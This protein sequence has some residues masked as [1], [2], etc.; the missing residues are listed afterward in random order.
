MV[1]DA[2]SRRSTI[3]QC[4]DIDQ[5]GGSP[6]MSSIFRSAPHRRWPALVLGAVAALAGPVVAALIPAPAHAAAT[7]ADLCAQ[8]SYTAGF[9]DDPLVTA[10]AVGLAESSCNPSATHVNGSSG[11]CSSSIDRG[12]YQINS[13]FHAEVSD[14]CAFDAQCNANE[15]FRISSHG[16]NW[17][18]WSAFNSGAYTGHLDEAEAAVERLVP[19][20]P[21]LPRRPLCHPVTGDWDGNGTHTLG[22]VCRDGHGM[23]W[24]LMNI[25]S[26]GTPQ[27]TGGY[28]NSDWCVPVTGDWDGDGRTSA[29]VACKNGTGITWSLSNGFR[30]SP[31]I[32]VFGFGN[33]AN[34][35]PVTGDWDGNG[36]DTIGVACKSGHGLTWSLMNFNGGG[37]PQITGSFGNSDTCLPV[38]GDWDGTGTDTIGVACKSGNGIEWSLINGFAGSPSYPVFGF[39]NSNGCRPVTG[40]WDG[41]GTDT[42]GVACKSGHGL[43]WGLMNFHGGGSP[44]I[45]AGF[46]NGDSYQPTGGWGGP[47]WPAWPDFS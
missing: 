42:I 9:R 41:N 39:G 43:S 30:G 3:H 38:T 29:G 20:P 8:V 2:G 15:T 14:S 11:S 33:S 1:P 46:G 31:S 37:S 40:D 16:T 35:W 7:A 32:P 13:C 17:T 28:G 6:F 21:A 18:P 26:G 10:V 19:P 25:N 45:T 12:L 34:C 23:S 22:V 27:I 4:V 5:N 24:D 47:A 44:Q 36:T